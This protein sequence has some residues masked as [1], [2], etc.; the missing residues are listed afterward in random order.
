MNRIEIAV[1]WTAFP[2]LISLFLILFLNDPESSKELYDFVV[3]R[4]G[5]VTTTAS[6][7]RPGIATGVASGSRCLRGNM[8][9][10]RFEIRVP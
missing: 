1:Y 5:G 6:G 3:F 10:G 7:Q 4:S 9:R 8:A 2:A